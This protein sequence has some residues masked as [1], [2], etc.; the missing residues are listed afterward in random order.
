MGW[1]YDFSSWR[2]VILLQNDKMEPCFTLWDLSDSRH[3][4]SFGQIGNG[5][6][7]ERL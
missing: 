1:Y 6:D 4:F 3:Y 7:D 2:P 5:P